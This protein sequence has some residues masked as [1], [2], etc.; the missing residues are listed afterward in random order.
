VID[1]AAAATDP[2][3]R[4]RR[5]WIQALLAAGLALL[6]IAPLFQQEIAGAVRVWADSSAY[7][8]CF[9][10]IP[11]SLYLIWERRSSLAETTPRPTLWGLGLILPLSIAWLLAAKLDV[12]EAQQ[13]IVIAIVEAML[14]TLLGGAVFRGL[15]GPLLYLFFLV[16]SGEFLVPPLQDFTARF[17][18]AG[19]RL[20]GVPVF[21]DGTFIDI[22]EGGFVIAEA[23]AGLRFLVASV[24][25]GVLFALL[26]YRSPGRRI[27]F[28]ALAIAVPILANG[29][30]AFGIIYAAHLIGSAS[31]AAA[32]HVLYGWIFFTLVITLLTLLGLSF[33]E[34][35]PSRTRPGSPAPETPY[36][37]RGRYALIVATA[38]ALAI[39][40]PAFSLVM[41]AS[42]APIAVAGRELPV[43]GLHWQHEAGAPE[44]RPVV[45][46]A[47]RELSDGFSDGDGR[48]D[49]FVALYA[50]RG[51]RNNLVRSLNRLADE[52][53][54][55]RANS[56]SERVTIDGRGQDIEAT[57]IV[58]G[59]RSRLVW[60][61]YVVDGRIVT[62]K[63][64]TKLY[65]AY[66]ALRGRGRVAGF[67]ALSTDMPDP[68]RPPGERLARFIAGSPSLAGAIAEMR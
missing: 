67:V 40:G 58:S 24:A 54:W 2:Q 3:A 45:V 12:L 4:R 66:A 20:L 19:L 60:S 39:A 31:A 50:M 49:R 56:W 9:L 53:S 41:D 57:E 1:L 33:A 46:G 18:V 34:R 26:V 51:N 27:V 25:Y 13:F 63:L 10:I 38:V 32:D 8:H 7:N 28:I 17:A 23:C 64:A 47:D 61:F 59:G 44:W 65:Q 29:L 15:L 5:S 21:S 14:F 42:A 62:G 6:A 43:P 55:R 16:P 30:R 35:A 36:S 22:P 11:I 37:S 52:K 48:V 68:T